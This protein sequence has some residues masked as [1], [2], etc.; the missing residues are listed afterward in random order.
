MRYYKMRY[1]TRK[2]FSSWW[3][4]IFLG[5]A[6][7]GVIGFGT[8]KDNKERKNIA[9]RMESIKIAEAKAK[10]EKFV[11]AIS[12]KSF[13]ASLKVVK[14][15]VAFKIED[16]NLVEIKKFKENDVITIIDEVNGLYILNINGIKSYIPVSYLTH[17]KG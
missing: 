13:P 10:E 4:I 7:V 5:I 12:S 17:I 15:V 2:I 14:D 6:T 9:N 8:I 3:F 11:N 16:N 1:Y